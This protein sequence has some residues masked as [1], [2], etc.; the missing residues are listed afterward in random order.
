MKK[1]TVDIDEFECVKS[2]LNN[3]YFNLSASPERLNRYYYFTEIDWSSGLH[4]LL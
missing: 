1:F 2:E 3:V 4:V